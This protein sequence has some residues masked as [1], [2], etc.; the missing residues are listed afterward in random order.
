MR[1]PGE[2]PSASKSGEERLFV[3]YARQLVLWGLFS[4][5]GQAAASAQ[6]SFST[7]IDMALRN[8]PQVRMGAAEVARAA[9]GLTESIG[10]YKPSLVLGSSLGFTYGFP[11]G[12]PEVFS[13]SA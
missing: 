10:V 3:R 4:L 9:A 5:L 13:L 7:T 2:F 12:Q 1:L 8:S 6:L 11:L